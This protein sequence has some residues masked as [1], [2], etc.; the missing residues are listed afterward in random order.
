ML[1]TMYLQIAVRGSAGSAREGLPKYPPA[2]KRIVL[3]NGIWAGALKRDNVALVTEPIKEITPRGVVD[4]GR[5]GARGG[6]A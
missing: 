6:R 1:L 3:D 5:R 4:E 2:S